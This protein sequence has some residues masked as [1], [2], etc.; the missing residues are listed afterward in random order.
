MK[1]FLQTT[2]LI[3]HVMYWPLF[4]YKK[5]LSLYCDGIPCLCFCGRHPHYD[6][7]GSPCHPLQLSAESVCIPYWRNDQSL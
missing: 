5:R 2:V 6:S 1:Q 4:H 3:K 7:E